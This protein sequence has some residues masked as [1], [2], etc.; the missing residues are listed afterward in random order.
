M[1]LVNISDPTCLNAVRELA[2]HFTNPTKQQWRALTRLIGRIKLNI[3]KGRF[4]QRPKELRL[5]ASTDSEYTNDEKN[6]KSITEG[7][8]TME[9]HQHTLYQKCNH[10][11]K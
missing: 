11:Q 5:A 3:G 2:Q 8:V 7:V 9:D 10:Q 4:L 6:R 1:Y